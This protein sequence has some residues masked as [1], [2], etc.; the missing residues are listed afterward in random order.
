MSGVSR[1]DLI[2]ASNGW[3]WNGDPTENFAGPNSRSY[4]RREIIIW[5]DNVKLRYGSGPNDNPW[6]WKYMEEYTTKAAKLFD[7]LRLDNCHS[8]P[9]HVS[10]RLTDVARAANKNIVILAELFTGSEKVDSKYANKLGIS[11]FIR[12]ALSANNVQEQGHLLHRFGGKSVGSFV[13]RS[14]EGVLRITPGIP[15]S[16]FM[17]VTH[18]NECIKRKR[19]LK[20]SVPLAALVS[21]S[22]SAI[23]STRGFDEILHVAVDVVKETRL[24]RTLLHTGAKVDITNPYVYSSEG[25][26]AVKAELNCM[27]RELNRDGF[28]EQYTEVVGRLISITRANPVTLEREIIV[29]HPCF[30]ENIAC[31]EWREEIIL[32]GKIE[33]IRMAAVI[34]DNA[35]WSELLS[36][37]N[38]Y[39]R[40]S[41]NG[42]DV[43]FGRDKTVEFKE[44]KVRLTKVNKVIAQVN[45]SRGVLSVDNN[46]FPPGSTLVFKVSDFASHVWMKLIDMVPSK[47]LFQD[48]TLIDMNHLLFRCDDEEKLQEYGPSCLY[49][50]PRYGPLKYC[51][52]QGIMTVFDIV[53]KRDELGHPLCENIREGPWL[54]DY[55]IEHIKKGGIRLKLISLWVEKVKDKIYTVAKAWRPVGL[56]ILLCKLYNK[57]LEKIWELMSDFVK[58]GKRITQMLAL[59]SVQMFGLDAAHCRGSSKLPSLAAGL[60]HFASGWKRTWGRDTFISLRGLMLVPGRFQEAHDI[61]LAF[62]SSVHNGLVP[63]LWNGGTKCR[64]NCRD[65][66]WFF[67]Q[68][69]QDFCKLVPG[70][71]EWILREK[72]DYEALQ[73]FES[74][75][76]VRK[77]TD[78]LLANVIQD[79][80]QSHATGI[81]FREA[82]AGP[83]IDDRMKSSGFDVS[84]YLDIGTGLICGGNIY[85]C[86]TW[87]DKLGESEKA[88]N[89][90]VPA[91]PRDGAAIEINGLVKSAVRWLADLWERGLY[92]CEGVK[93]MRGEDLKWADW[94]AKLQRNFERAFWVPKDQ[95][96][97]KKYAIDGSVVS[98]R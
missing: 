73:S 67:L 42:W 76:V 7:G 83:E 19:S 53:R 64:Y 68:A 55:L 2:F 95:T 21:A 57:A 66:A 30:N 51:G 6:L 9:L 94:N 10:T 37:D 97:D 17:D 16:I 88:G 28:L 23:G 93:D 27:H 34:K 48:V 40:G 49:N 29:V 54:T 1:L 14:R 5:G 72:I 3:I 32:Q 62:A 80:M 98:R 91:T 33:N 38:E 41:Q 90:G 22:A 25:I 44:G 71:G 87:M 24:Y 75:G 50:I 46:S 26:I 79:I 45:I 60:P 59:G 11:L 70:G 61:I 43:G 77:A 4:L 8:T 20:D 58:N 36:H 39:L 52:L 74:R 78:K 81:S 82:N 13:S 12:E 69:I 47:E 56:D 96:E 84:A 35:N 86:G 65:A 63:N 85:N 89:R 15:A 92:Y 31:D 18:D